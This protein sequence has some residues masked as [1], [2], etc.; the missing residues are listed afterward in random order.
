MNPFK[1]FSRKMKPV[2]P[3][4]LRSVRGKMVP[5]PP[6]KPGI[7]KKPDGEPLLILGKPVVADESTAAN[8]LFVFDEAEGVSSASCGS[9]SGFVPKA[10]IEPSV[11]DPCSTTEP[12]P[13]LWKIEGQSQP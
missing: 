13:A 3:M 12:G 6:G 1:S 2:L 10:R 7:V 8:L 11:T 5:V 4:R 9:A